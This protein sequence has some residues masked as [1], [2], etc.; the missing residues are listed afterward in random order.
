MGKI[1]R[2][3]Y[4]AGG[5]PKLHEIAEEAGMLHGAQLPRRKPPPNLYFADQDWR[6][7]DRE[8]YMAALAKYRPRMATV[9]DI[10]RPELLDEALS[11]AEEAAQYVREVVL[12]PKVHNIVRLIPE[13]IGD[14]RVVLGYSV[15]TRYGASELMLWEFGNR[16]VHL[17][18]GSPRQQLTL[19]RYLNVTSAD[20]NAIN[21]G[22][23]A[24]LS[25]W[26]GKR[27]TLLPRG[28]KDAYIEAFRISV[29]AV[30]AMWRER[31]YQIAK[32][33]DEPY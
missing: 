27:W 23:T 31:G 17:L 9:I 14:A 22:A 26:N 30:V 29:H 5:N 21:R 1:I 4:C 16:P 20:G 19:S 11:W 33:D 12:I 7:P 6:K 2:V 28:E 8:K 32:F 10:D 24:Y 13:R 15:P 18:G 25:A 3:I